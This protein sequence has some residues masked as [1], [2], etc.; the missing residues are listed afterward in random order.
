MSAKASMSSKRSTIS[1]CSIPRIRPLSM[2]FSRPVKSGLNPVPMPKIADR[3]PRTSTSPVVGRKTPE[4]MLKSV[5]FP[6][7]LRPTTPRVVPGSTSRLKSCSAQNS[8]LRLAL[9]KLRISP[10]LEDRLGEILYFLP[11]PLREM[12]GVTGG[13]QIPASP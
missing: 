8:W 4:I 6:A 13:P 7:P 11:I 2:A 10:S 3:R 12:A 5:L 9:P 1:S